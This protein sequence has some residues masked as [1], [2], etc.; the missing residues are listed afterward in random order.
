MVLTKSYQRY[1]PAGVFG[2]IA[3]P[4]ANILSYRDQSNVI[5]APALEDV[6][7]WDI[8]LGRKLAVY[9]GD[10]NAEVTALA[11]SSNWVH[12]AVGYNDG[13]IKLWNTNDGSSKVTLSGHK[14]A[15]TV[16]KYDTTNTRLVS[17]SKDSNVILWD[18]VNETGLFR[19]K[20]HKDAI[21]QCCF[22]RNANVLITSSKDS[23]LKFWDLDTQHCYHT[24]LG[25]RS[26]VWD[27]VLLRNQ[28]RL[29][30]GCSD[31]QLRVWDLVYNKHDQTKMQHEGNQESKKD[32]ETVNGAVACQ[33]KGSLMRQSKE[34]LITILSDE[35]VL[36]CLAADAQLEIFRIR[37]DQE[38]KA[39]VKRRM[40]RIAKKSKDNAE[41]SEVTLLQPTLEDEYYRIY[42]I[43]CDAKIRF[44]KLIYE[45]VDNS[46]KVL[47]LLNNNSLEI[48]QIN[49]GV[50][51]IQCKVT[52]NLHA[53]GH[54]TVIRSV[55]FSGDGR[56]VASGASESVKIWNSSS[57]QS[58]RTLPSG[59]VLSMFFAPGDRQIIVGTRSGEI[60]IFDIA[61]GLMLETVQAHSK[62]VWSMCL[63]PDKRGFVSGGADQNVQFWEFELISDEKFSSSSKR[64]SITLIRTLQ[65]SEDV[66]AV[67]YSP[68]QRLLGVALLD[69]T[70]K[71]FYSDTLKFFLSLYGHKL[72]VLSMDI[73]SDST[74]IATASS[75]KNVKLWGLDF[76]DCHKSIFAHDDR[77]NIFIPRTHLFFTASK[78]QTIKYWDG[79][80]FEYITAMKGHHGEIWSIAV[81]PNG[82]FLVS[83]SHDRS[84]RMWE[85]S[86]QLV[87]VEEERE[88]ERETMFEESTYNESSDKVIPG[89]TSTEVAMASKTTIE[90]VKSAER[91]IEAI[92]IYE[93][94]L[95]ERENSPNQNGPFNQILKA[96]GDIKAETYVLNTL[97]KI[98]SSELEEALLVLP[99]GKVLKFVKLT[100]DWI[101]NDQELE[102]VC[103]CLIFLL[104]VNHP[105]LVANKALMSTLDHLKDI[106]VKKI[107]S[108]RDLLGFNLA[109]LQ[110][111]KREMESNDITFFVDSD[112]KLREIKKRRKVK[113]YI[114]QFRS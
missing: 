44:V 2:V 46:L 67:K 21:T 51:A 114:P 24:L 22:L 36:G 64:L 42:A 82:N 13:T 85:R 15:I 88:L 10:Q 53:L 35:A 8:R 30:S 60:Q 66:L 19:L 5:V 38:I 4:N 16:L 78:D 113:R 69:C 32:E 80:K 75:D 84:L 97:K 76:G 90:T 58:I 37:N 73:S 55:A 74:L 3:S 48:Q 107:S 111:I 18:V 1:Q 105:Q 70:V 33:Y 31:S 11:N 112:K 56:Y 57:H 23:M 49:Y 101:K 94:E 50:K 25:H 77:Y 86:D 102:L 99:F 12:I 45:A 104:K 54:R 91:I 9:H 71:I 93:E 95:R 27:F 41:S 43:R 61:S 28:T 52:N 65:M 89:E 39:H 79:D 7:I 68:D 83:S 14:S 47:L 34:R 40:K 63:N 20:G 110:H 62:N 108:Q 98:K 106:T 26:E 100:N 103:R 17:G 87:F 59:Y 29:I 96:L 6:Y 81:S 72:P 109:G 92:D